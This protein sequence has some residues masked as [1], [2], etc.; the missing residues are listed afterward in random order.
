[1]NDTLKTRNSCLLIKKNGVKNLINQGETS[2]FKRNK[3][4]LRVRIENKQTIKKRLTR[5]GQCG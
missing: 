3:K 1:M 4:R 5:A 2:T